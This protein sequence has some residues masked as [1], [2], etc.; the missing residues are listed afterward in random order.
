MTI[1]KPFDHL[2]SASGGS[3]ETKR[4]KGESW[5]P[6]GHDCSMRIQS[7]DCYPTGC[8]SFVVIFI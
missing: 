6:A 2:L 5:R 3:N 8:C 1:D 4:F 7:A